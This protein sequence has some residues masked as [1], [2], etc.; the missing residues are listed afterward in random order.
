MFC[1]AALVLVY[2][3]SADIVDHGR[4]VTG[5]DHAGLYGSILQ[6]C[7]KSLQGVSIALGIALVGMSGF[8]ATAEAQTPAGVLGIKLVASVVPALGMLLGAAIMWTYPLTRARVAEIQAE[9]HVR[10]AAAA[11]SRPA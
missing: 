9:L 5:E 2:A 4:L 11:A 1:V 6:F 3:I 10:D 8:D 7:V